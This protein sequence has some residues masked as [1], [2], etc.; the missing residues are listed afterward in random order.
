[1]QIM[2]KIEI[3]PIISEK[4][5]KLAENQNTY[6]F[7]IR[8]NFLNKIE[9]KKHIE[10]IFNVK[11]KEVRTINYPKRKRGRSRIPSTRPKF[12]KAYV[13]LESGYKIPIFE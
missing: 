4:T 3:L 1:M 13:K 7:K 5:K 12:K 9:I 6:V 11:V 2:E 8:P 10:K